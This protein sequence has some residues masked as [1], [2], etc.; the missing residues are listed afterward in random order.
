M[1]LRREA[2]V[3]R[4]LPDTDPATERLIRAVFALLD[5]SP[6]PSAEVNELKGAALAWIDK[7]LDRLEEREEVEE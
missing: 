2:G 5:T 1:S 7:A 6:R 3:G 4:A